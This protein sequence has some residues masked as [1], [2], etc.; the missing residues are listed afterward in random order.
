M[1]VLILCLGIAAMFVWISVREKDSV[2]ELPE[3]QNIPPQEGV[4]ES[5]DFVPVNMNIFDPSFDRD[6]DRDGLLDAEETTLGTSSESFDSDND[7]LSDRSEIQFW[8]TSPNNS[9]SD[10][11]GFSDGFEVLNGYNPA[12]EGTIP[13]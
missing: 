2:E 6:K 12:G 5:N 4:N 1:F 13:Q 8:K 3:Q 11:D 9:D 7:G 10:G